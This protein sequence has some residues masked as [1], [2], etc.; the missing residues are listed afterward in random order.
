MASWSGVVL[1][2]GLIMLV[3]ACNS[4]GESKGNTTSVSATPTVATDVSAGFDACKDLPQALIQSE[5]LKNKGVD[6][7]DGNGG[8]K[9]RGCIWIQSDGYSTTID[10][11]NITLAM[12]RANHD[13]AIDD[14]L[15]VAGRPA[16]TSYV[17]GQDP[18]A[19]CVINVEL[20]GGSLEISVDNPASRRKSGTQHSCEIAKRLA[21]QVVPAIPATL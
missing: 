14:E 12:V 13:F 18:K 17:S 15:T 21:V 5:E 8:I 6:N 1:G 19:D 11:T 20:K 10:T 9:W 7:H 16:L 4:S 3:S 2:A